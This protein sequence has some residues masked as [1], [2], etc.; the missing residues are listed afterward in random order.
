[1]KDVF[2]ALADLQM[3]AKELKSLILVSTPDGGG[4]SLLREALYELETALHSMERATA[5]VRQRGALTE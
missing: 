2:I 4:V 1:M 3:R 5:E